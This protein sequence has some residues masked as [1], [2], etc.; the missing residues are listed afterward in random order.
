LQFF[1]LDTEHSAEPSEAAVDRLHI[2]IYTD[3]YKLAIHRAAVNNKQSVGANT[4]YTSEGLDNV[5]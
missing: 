4:V 1:R 3:L 5:A 2:C